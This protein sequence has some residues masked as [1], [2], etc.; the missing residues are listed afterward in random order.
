VPP[1]RYSSNYSDALV[2]H[3]KQGYSFES[4]AGVVGVARSTLYN[5]LEQYPA[6][7]EAKEIGESYS[8]YHYE[9]I[10]MQSMHNDDE[11]R[12]GFNMTSLIFNMCNRHGWNRSPKKEDV[13]PP[14]IELNISGLNMASI[15]EG[16]SSP[17]VP[18]APPE[19]AKK[20]TPKTTKA[21]AKKKDGV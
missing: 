1:N 6:F 15:S 18:K 16:S 3:M 21:K 20:P 10:L 2:E 8:L 7:A 4:Y 12:N 11:G 9:K 14:R 17:E 5:W 19:K 13:A